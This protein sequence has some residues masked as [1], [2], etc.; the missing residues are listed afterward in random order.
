MSQPTSIGGRPPAP[1]PGM[2]APPEL[3]I[4]RFRPHAHRLFWSAVVLIAVCGATGWLWGN[5]PRPFENW[6]LVAAASVIV[7]L[8]VLLPFVS[9][10]SHLY[11]IT[12]RRVMERRG[13]VRVRRRE[14]EHVR[15]YTVHLRR[16]PLQRMWGTGT[17]TL[18]NGVEA[19]MKLRNVPMAVLVHETLVD[20]V[21]VS[22]IL[23]HR[24]AASIPIAAPPA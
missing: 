22:Q 24:D 1:A 11:T 8:L 20:Q 3:R 9:W 19:Q 5:V 14:L 2:P 23:A 10:W 12:T 13:I 18:S 6:M 15:G 16:G 21:E 17:L 7:L 4:A